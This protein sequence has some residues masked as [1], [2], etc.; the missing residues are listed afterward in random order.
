M[1]QHI[2]IVGW[3]H[4]GFG[5]LWIGMAVFGGALLSVIGLASGEPG[6]AG[7][8]A[9]IGGILVVVAGLLSVPTLVAGWGLLRRKH[10]ARMLTL[11]LSFLNLLNFPLG[12]L[13]GG[14]SIWVLMQDESR[15]ILSGGDSYTHLPR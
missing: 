13:L 15:Q 7:I 12:T 8:M 6:A 5:L 3:I 2:D 9:A 14:Y 1:R 11:I 10:W 4:I